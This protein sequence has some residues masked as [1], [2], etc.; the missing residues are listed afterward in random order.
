LVRNGRHVSEGGGRGFEIILETVRSATSTPSCKRSPLQD[1]VKQ[2]EVGRMYRLTL[3]KFIAVKNGKEIRDIVVDEVTEEDEGNRSGSST[4][5]GADR[6][7][8]NV[9]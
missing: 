9:P 2:L 6:G 4:S 8:W 5:Q 3:E 7:R 1:Q